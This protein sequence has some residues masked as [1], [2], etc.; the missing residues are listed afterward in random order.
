MD[1]EN[2][3]NF[4]VAAE[5]GSF[6]Q[7]GR[8]LDLTTSTVI[9]RIDQLEGQ[10]GARL[11]NRL[12]RGIQLT[13]EGTRL[14]A[15][16]QRFRQ[17][18]EDFNREVR[19]FGKADRGVVSLAVTEGLGAY[20]LT[21]RLLEYKRAHPN[22]IVELY[23]DHHSADVAGFGA[24][25]CVQ[26]SEPSA[27]DVV[28]VR[29]GFLHL[30]PFASKAYLKEHGLPAAKEDLLRHRFVEQVGPQFDKKDWARHLGLDDT[31][32]CVGF[33]SNSSTANF[34]AIE[35]DGGIGALP[36]YAPLLGAKVVPLDLGLHQRV[37]IWM[38][39]HRDNTQRPA[40]RKVIDFLRDAFDTQRYPWFGEAFV[41]PAELKDHAESLSGLRAPRRSQARTPLR[42][43]R[44]DSA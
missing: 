21:P 25:I 9:R 6:R 22:L 28:P 37:D 17:A 8:D 13:R 31:D 5:A 35:N 33:R 12:A 30:Y 38:S 10:V 20:W 39:W 14:M 16:A 11:F 4:V 15:S 40:M 29:L 26:F 44:K 7:A 36:N 3:H 32:D 18:E 1:W 42:K 41:H 24:D 2:I 27:P 23:C 34:I 19:S 43:M